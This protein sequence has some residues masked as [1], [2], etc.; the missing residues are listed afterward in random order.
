MKLSV[1]SF[2]KACFRFS[3]LALVVGGVFTSAQASTIVGGSNLLNAASTQQLTDWLGAGDLQLTNLFDKT[4]GQTSLNFHTAVDGRGATFSLIEVTGYGGTALRTPI[5]IGGYNPQSWD[6]SVGNFTNTQPGAKQTAFI[7]NLTE[8]A[9]F[10]QIGS[11]VETTNIYGLGPSFGDGDI[12]V[13][14]DLN[15]GASGFTTYGPVGGFNPYFD[16]GRANP[17]I[18]SY[19]SP[20]SYPSGYSNGIFNVGQIEVFSVSTSAIPEPSTYA[21]IFGVVALGAATFRRRAVRA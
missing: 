16:F 2:A 3:S 6:G 14:S 13:Y 8:S 21:A 20:S 9:V 18:V 7:F 17:D 19:P 11:I 10:H 12:W 4:A 5:V 1:T 15:G